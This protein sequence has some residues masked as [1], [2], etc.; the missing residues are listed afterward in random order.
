MFVDQVSI[1]L[2]GGKGGDGCMSFRR[3]KYVPKGGPDGGNGGHGGSVIIQAREG[4]SSLSF[5]ANRNRWAASKGTP[6]SGSNRHGRNGKDLLIEVPPGTVVKDAAGEFILKDLTADEEQVIAAR[7]GKGGKGNAHFKS[8]TNQVPRDWTPGEEGE[9]RKVVLELKVIADVG[10]IGKPN[11]GK[12]T[13]LSRLSRAR[14]EIAAYPF[15]T[16]I[17]TLVRYKLTLI[18]RL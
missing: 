13:L 4:V 5:L 2:I 3:E 7:G 10:L 15:T 16:K 18:V 11:A 14:P 17:P 12:S 9:S 1:E 8:S 6:G